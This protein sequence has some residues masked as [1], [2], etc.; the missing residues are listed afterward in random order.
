VNTSP[1]SSQPSPAARRSS[2]WLP[3]QARNAC[4]AAWGG[5]GCGGTVRSW[6]RRAPAPTATPPRAAA[7][8]AWRPGRRPGRRG[9]SAGRGLL[10]CGSRSA[11]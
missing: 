7:P 6:S 10:R 5:Q 1:V 8:G 11:G 3:D 9:P 2:A 4:T